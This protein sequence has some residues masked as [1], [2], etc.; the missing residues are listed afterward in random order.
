LSHLNRKA[1]LL[2][3]TSELAILTLVFLARENRSAPQP[4][5]SIADNISCS[6]TYLAKI[7]SGLARAGLVETLRGKQGG[8]CLTR[9]SEEITLRSIVEA[10]QGVILPDYC[11][12]DITK[13]GTPCGFHLAM[14]ELHEAIL[15]V[16]EKWTLSDLI[17]LPVDKR[18]TPM[19]GGC[20]MSSKK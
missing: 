6:P 3:K 10:S 2:T 8:V 12:Q 11:T 1:S 16:M 17:T 15:A 7:I 5:K 4:P 18:G 9:N 19:I 20:K 14:E 13:V